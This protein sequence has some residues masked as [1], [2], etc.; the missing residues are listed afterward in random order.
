MTNR[1]KQRLKKHNIDILIELENDTPDQT[2]EKL[3]N[4]ALHIADSLKQTNLK[5]LNIT[6]F[7]GSILIRASHKKVPH[8][9]YGPYINIDPNLEG[10]DEAVSQ[11]IESWIKD[12][13]ETSVNSFLR[14]IA[15]GE[16][17]GWD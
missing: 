15:D 7:S 3:T 6:P 4:T 11:F 9:Y 10:L 14:F 2:K 13:N 1:T 16:K 12:D 17:Y 5:Q 8:Y